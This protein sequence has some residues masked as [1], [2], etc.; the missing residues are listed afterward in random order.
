MKDGSYLYCIIGTA[1][2]RNFGPIGIGDSRDSVTTISFEDISAVISRSPL[3][4]YPLS[5]ENLLA[6]QRV[7]EEVM[8]DHTVL[9]VRFSTIAESAEEIRSVLRTRCREFKGLMRDMDNKVELGVKAVWKNMDDVFRA[10]AMA[11]GGIR[12]LKEKLAAKGASHNERISLGGLVE[13][14]LKRRREEEAEEILRELRPIAVDARE[15]RLHGD[16][17]LVNSAFLVDSSMVREFDS[18][19][20][21]LDERCEGTVRLKYVGPVPPFNFVNIVIEWGRRGGQ[22]ACQ[23]G[24]RP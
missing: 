11:D 1:E 23:K 12:R 20:R 7:I 21:E 5:R 4:E 3:A 24:E 8:K 10:I 19:I 14:A 9:P 13:S 16:N 2:A 18:R 6:H 15:N 22:Y 17:M